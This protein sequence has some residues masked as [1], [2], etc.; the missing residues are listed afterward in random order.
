MEQNIFPQEYFKII[1]Y[2]CQLTKNIKYVVGTTQFD[3][4]KSN[5]F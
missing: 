4:C 5:G 1:W 2:L 3:L